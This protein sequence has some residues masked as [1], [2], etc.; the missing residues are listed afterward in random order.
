MKKHEH[1]HHR[2]SIEVER[3]KALIVNL[4]SRFLGGDRFPDIKSS[5]CFR[6][7]DAGCRV[8]TW[9]LM[10]ENFFRNRARIAFGLDGVYPLNLSSRWQA[11]P[12]ASRDF[13]DLFGNL[14]EFMDLVVVNKINLLLNL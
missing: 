11:S 4:I 14:T 9:T 10:I 2:S 3:I 13:I 5:C 7:R 12:W 8:K 1:T 6:W